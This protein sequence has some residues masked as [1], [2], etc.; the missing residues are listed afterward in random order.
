MKHQCQNCPRS[1]AASEIAARAARWI[2]WSGTTI[3]GK[4]T[5]R[6]FC[7]TCA[8]R[9]A[10]DAHPPTWDAECATCHWRMSDADDWE[11]DD[12][13]YTEKDA[14]NWETDHQCE[15]DVRLITPEEI[16]QERARLSEAQDRAK[17][18]KARSAAAV[19]A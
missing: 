11:D 19:N 12:E 15:P 6:I 9:E 17:A 14:R 7:P 13:P 10:Q 2:V 18:V 8:G 4:E 16:E 3:G 1:T 5:T